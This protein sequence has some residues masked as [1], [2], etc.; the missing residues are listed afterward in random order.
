MWYGLHGMSHNC[1]R[2]VRTIQTDDPRAKLNLELSSVTSL[3]CTK[4]IL[5][6]LCMCYI[7]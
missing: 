3:L 6:L 4:N 1:V 5:E 7:S 2:F